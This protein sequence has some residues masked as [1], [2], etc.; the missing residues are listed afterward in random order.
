MRAL[1]VVT[2]S[3][4]P[5]LEPALAVRIG[6]H[7]AVELVMRCLDRVE[8][9]GAIRALELDAIVSVGAPT[10]LD[11]QTMQEASETGVRI[12]GVSDDPGAVRELTSRGITVLDSERDVD[13]IVTACRAHSF[14]PTIKSEAPPRRGRLI[15]VWGPKG[16]PGRTMIAIRLALQL[17]RGTP[18]TLLIDADPYGG[19]V[20]Q[21]FGIV[22]E[23]PTVVWA[24]N[25]AAKHGFDAQ[26]LASD[27]RRAAPGGPVV[28]P[29]LPRAELWAEVS[30]FGWR[31][32]L[33]AA[34]SSFAF[35]ICDIG[36]CLESDPS[37]YPGAGE[38]R[39]RMARAAATAADHVV[40]VV[41]GD[42]LG[43]KSFLWAFESL[44]QICSEERVIVVLNRARRGEEKEIAELV[45]RHT[46]KRLAAVLLERPQ[47]CLQRLEQKGK[48]SGPELPAGIRDLAAAV[49][50]V[51]PARG[52]L[53][54][55]GGR[56]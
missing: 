45:R 54:R 1:R 5:Q 14:T 19:D 16:A 29:G 23:L 2:L 44:K 48:W 24:A 17:S 43:I 18:D 50:G 56:R 27:L 47:L 25:A 52:V 28:I 4:E 22:E 6:S 11:P 26:T 40:A 35:T 15:S 41:R 55:M 8:L 13:A 10:W 51:V 34:Q 53:S 49:G 21:A 38:G 9:L 39:N 42:A 7:P 3:G 31:R 20:L 37:P 30:D 12:V 36:F 33:S 46:G 32:L